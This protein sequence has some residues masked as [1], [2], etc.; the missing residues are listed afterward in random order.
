MV[1]VYGMVFPFFIV[2]LPRA[3]FC[4]S[5][6]YIPLSR[7]R[8]LE[9]CWSRNGWPACIDIFGCVVQSLVLLELF[10]LHEGIRFRPADVLYGIMYGLLVE[11]FMFLSLLSDTWYRWKRSLLGGCKS[12]AISSGLHSAMVKL[13][14]VGANLIEL[15]KP[16]LRQNSTQENDMA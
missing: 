13:G 5:K 6:I 3:L 4:I 9:R 7:S 16:L 2:P 12:V 14:I 1:A 11:V 15:G 10:L 8:Q